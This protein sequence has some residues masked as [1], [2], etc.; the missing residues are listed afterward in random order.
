MLTGVLQMED[1]GSFI[2]VLF[3]IIVALVVVV[4]F[5]RSMSGWN[6]GVQRPVS[7]AT[8]FPPPPPPDTVMVKCQYCGTQQVWKETCVK[9]GAPLPKPDVAKL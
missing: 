4:A 7:E 3:F 6:R 1:M 9:C 2:G 5:A 8:A